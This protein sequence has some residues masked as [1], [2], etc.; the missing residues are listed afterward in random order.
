MSLHDL[1]L[2]FSIHCK[3]TVTRCQILLFGTVPVSQ[4][5]LLTP[6]SKFKND[7]ID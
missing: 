1:V 4:I 6:H 7:L 5:L 3:S 2:I